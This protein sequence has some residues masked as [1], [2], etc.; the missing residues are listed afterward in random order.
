MNTSKSLIEQIRLVFPRETC[1]DY[2]YATQ[3]EWIETNGIGGFAS[4][5][6][7]GANVRRYH[8]L[9]V[10]P[11]G[12]GESIPHV[13]LSKL[14]ETMHLDG[15]NFDLSTNQYPFIIFPEG[16]HNIERFEYDLFPRFVYQLGGVIIQK[17]LLMLQGENTIL[18][19]YDVRR[20]D[21]PFTMSIRPLCAFR[22]AAKLTRENPDI[23]TN[24][25]SVDE[26]RF[27]FRPYAELPELHFWHSHGT[28]EEK[29]Y[30][31]KNTEYRKEQERGREFSEDLFSPAVL[32]VP[33]KEEDTLDIVVSTQA[34][35]IDHI[36]ARGA[37]VVFEDEV[38]RRARHVA[39]FPLEHP[40][41]R[42]MALTSESFFL[43]KGGAH[44]LM[45]GY[46]WDCD[47]SLDNAIA[48]AGLVLTPG[49]FDLARQLLPSHF[50]GIFSQ[51]ERVDTPLWY[52]L[53]AYNHGFFADDMVW[54]GEHLWPT[55]DAWVRLV[56][57]GQHGTASVS[58]NGLIR[59]EAY[60]SVKECYAGRSGMTV[61]IN[62]LWYNALCIL[63]DIA[64]EAR[65]KDAARYDPLI[66]KIRHAF[67]ETFWNERDQCLFDRVKD[68]EPDA[69]IRPYQ[70]LAVSLPFDLLDRTQ[71]K[72]IVGT[73]TRHLLTPFGL[74]S[75]SKH[76][77]EY[78]G[79]YAGPAENRKAAYHRGSVWP[80]MMGHYIEAYLKVEEF[81]PL[82][83]DHCWKL[84]EHFR[85]AVHDAGLHS[86][87][88][89][90]DGDEPHFPKGRVSDS[91]SVGEI[92]RVIELL[93]NSERLM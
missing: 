47:K 86:I 30:W 19:R 90:F 36:A 53:A 8:G 73:V 34:G 54:V 49:R 5:T 62:A 58:E 88:E 14:E 44:D 68:G 82:A 78:I 69:S 84:I 46:H 87:S 35:R 89:L 42:A 29:F 18:I 23:D 45:G 13:L 52:F 61:D 33:L 76:S 67:A 15:R 57:S 48:F 27:V 60:E 85:E 92:L 81:S 3:K 77:P 37:K 24:L 2:Y 41:A 75:L 83:R 28:T 9:L 32:H 10:V 26:K 7:I 4:S 91:K 39:D 59:C 65:S 64:K 22:E 51:T 38:E 79:V 93:E 11:A 20:A 40:M 16:H 71:R 74:R 1:S 80:W 31:Y 21:R 12:R 17:T 70:I 56:L 72:A 63:R 43:T 6:L 25:L 50:R 66:E 55:M